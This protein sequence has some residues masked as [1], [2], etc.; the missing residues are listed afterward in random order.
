MKKTLYAA[1][2]LGL[3]SCASTGNQFPIEKE[4][5]KSSPNSLI[6]MGLTSSSD[7]FGFRKPRLNW[8]KFDPST[9]SVEDEII[10]VYHPTGLASIGSDGEALDKRPYHIFEVSLGHYYLESIWQKYITR[11]GGGLTEVY[12]TLMAKKNSPSFEAR[13]GEITYIGDFRYGGE[14]YDIQSLSPAEPNLKKATAFLRAFPKIQSQFRSRPV[15]IISYEC[16][17][18]SVFFEDGFTCKPESIIISDDSH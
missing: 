17:E 1:I 3:V 12:R 5:D 9:N 10:S 14:G 16:E 13:S 4:F 18:T 7:F 8:R 2:F 15:K 11:K 6:V